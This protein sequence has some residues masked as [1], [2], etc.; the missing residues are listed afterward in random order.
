MLPDLAYALIHAGA[1]DVDT[2]TLV[3][4]AAQAGYRLDF[5]GYALMIEQLGAA[6]LCMMMIMADK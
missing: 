5:A 6:G 3:E 1:E 2:G 4:S